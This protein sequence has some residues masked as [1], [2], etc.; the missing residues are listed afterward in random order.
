MLIKLAFKNTSKNL[1]DYAVYFITLAFGVCVFYMFNSIYAQSDVIAVT[2][3]QLTS[4]IALREILSYISVFVAVVL[5]FLIV[6][7]NSFFIKRRKKELGIYMTLGMTRGGISTVLL[8]ETS[9]MAVIAL[10]VG[11]AAGIFGSQFMSVFTAKL[12]EADM[13]AYKFIF[14]PDAAVKSVIYFGV[15]FLTVIIFNIISIGRFKLVDLIYGGR[16]NETLRIKNIGAA[17]V[18]FILAVLCLVA[19]YVIILKNGLLYIN[20]WFLTSIILGSVGTLLFFLSLS[21]FLIQ[22]MQSNKRLYYKQLNMFVVRQL[23]SKVNTNFVSISVVCI[24]LLL[25]IGIFSCGYSVQKLLSDEL[26]KSTPYDYTLINYDDN[27]PEYTL[28]DALPDEIAKSEYIKDH[29]EYS[30][31]SFDGEGSIFADYDIDYDEAYYDGFG[32]MNMVFVGISDYNALRAL[33]GLN[34]YSL[35]DGQYFVICKSEDFM[36]IA[37]QFV[38]KKIPITLEGETLYPAGGVENIALSMSSD[39]DVAFIVPD[40]LCASMNI[41]SYVLDIQCTGDEGAASLESIISDY[42]SAP[43]RERAI[44]FYTSRIQT[45]ERAVSNKAMVAFL[46]VYLGIVFMIT[47]AAVLAIQQLFEAADNRERYELLRKL[48]AEHSMLDRALVTQI[49]CYFL[50]PLLL[51]IVHS[52]VGLTA[53]NNAISQ[54]GRMNIGSS[55]A[56][57]AAFVLFIYGIY[58]ALTCMGSKSIVNK[59]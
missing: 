3:L 18:V 19:A 7:A 38:S 46:A 49:F 30:P 53:A 59:G 57:T 37:K 1:R 45:Y 54:G 17:T 34:E 14:A 43:S 16:K 10:A 52:I 27:P 39:A 26:I 23:A 4:M 20:W 25:V 29:Y 8:L 12:F 36:S 58:F 55:I 42:M 51:A 22:I 2:E 21:G 9:I 56:A 48:G 50:L 13:T 41:N 47:C 35:E 33:Q 28:W 31:R 40:R 5:G 24:L 15:I 32:E 44:S 6:Y 11:L